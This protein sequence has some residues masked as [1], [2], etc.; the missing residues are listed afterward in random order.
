[1]NN[2]EQIKTHMEYLGYN[3]EMHKNDHN[4]MFCLKRGYAPL[5]VKCS[6]L[7]INFYAHHE[8]NNVAKSNIDKVYKYVNELNTVSYTATFN[9]VDDLLIMTGQFNG[10]YDRS[11]FSS[12]LG[13]MEHDTTEILRN[14]SNSDVFLGSDDQYT[15]EHSRLEAV[16]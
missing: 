2:N 3:I 7:M 15:N 16:A 10:I 13:A 6:D 14:N 1:M 12:F 8:L 4:V 11:N 9:T 5:M